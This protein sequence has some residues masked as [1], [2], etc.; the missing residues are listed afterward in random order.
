M[1]ELPI[2]YYDEDG[3]GVIYDDQFYL[4][5]AYGER[6]PERTFHSELN[7]YVTEVLR[8][9]LHDRPSAIFQFLEYRFDHEL[10][11]LTVRMRKAP[12]KSRV[13]ARQPKTRLIRAKVEPDLAVFIG[14]TIEADEASFSVGEDKDLPS[15][16]LLIETASPSTYL[17]DLDVKFNLYQDGLKAKEYVVFDPHEKRLWEGSRFRGWHLENG[18]YVPLREEGSGRFWSEVLQSWWVIEDRFLRLYDAEGNRRL[19]QLEHTQVLLEQEQA[20]K[21][22]ERAEKEAALR[23][24]AEL[25]ARLR[26]LESGNNE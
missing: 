14:T 13:K 18:I 24:I 7:R 17:N 8:W 15:P 10:S 5:D 25:E 9:M 6:V 21:E 2:R 1:D 3:A 22:R 16:D 19:T 20:E 11:E 12:T 23:R 4:Y 26:A